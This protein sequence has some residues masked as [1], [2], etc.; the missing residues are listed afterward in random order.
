MTSKASIDHHALV[1]LIRKCSSLKELKLIHGNMFRTGSIHDTFLASKLIESSAISMT[2]HM[3]YAHVVFSQIHHPNT[4]MWNTMIRGYSVSECSFQALSLYQQML[5]SGSLPNS[6]TFG[7]VLKACC[8]LLR[9]QEGKQV[10]AQ[11]VKSGLEFE[12]PVTN[13]LVRL[14]VSCGEVEAGRVLFDEMPQKDNISWSIIVTGY[15]QNGR[16]REALSVFREMQAANV[17]IDG[18]TL[19][20]VLGVC[21]NTGALA[22]G[23]WVHSYIDRNLVKIDVA[24]GTS[25]VDMYSKC[26]AV[27]DAH[28]VF[29]TM[30]EKDVM[31]WSGMIGGFAIH[32][33]GREALQVFAEMKKRKVRP[34]A[35]TFTSVLSACS[36]SGLVEEGRRNFNS[37]QSD[38]KIEPQIEHYGCMVDLYCRAGLVDQAHE[39]IIAMPIEPNSILWRT[40]LA[41]CKLHGKTKLGESISRKVLALDPHSAENYVL[42]SNVYASRG[43]WSKVSRIRGLMKTNGAKKS[44]G[45]SSIEV[46]FIVHQF[47]MGDE[48]HPETGEIYQMLDKMSKRLKREGYVATTGYVLHDIDEEEKENALGL[49][50]ER[51]ALAYGLLH[52][53]EASQ[54]RIVKNLRV[55]GD[56]HSAIKLISKVYK[57]EIIVRDRVRFHHFREG[58]CSCHDYW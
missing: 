12:L 37:M 2:G 10:H 23:K 15:A 4:F 6:F 13:G 22:L 16:D 39:F 19:A 21:G 55:C 17:E 56:C 32:G 50:S 30:V 48:S 28:R 46:N 7:F 36:H 9:L 54:I 44:N 40:L 11:T 41:A 1:S 52:T 33:F 18:F 34:T 49:H 53:C 47:V 27:G 51:L 26:G 14:Y 43:N 25:L 35:V 42:V 3:D 5:C 20:T 45:W 58:L 29:E 31:A 57:R 38:Y 8:R 24:L